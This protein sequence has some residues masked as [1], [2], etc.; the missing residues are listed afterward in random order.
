MKK[1][2]LAPYAQ[3]S[4]PKYPSRRQFFKSAAALIAA[5]ALLPSTLL[6][7]E[8]RKLGGVKRR[9]DYEDYRLPHEGYAI[10][11]LKDGEAEF[12]VSFSVGGF[13]DQVHVESE[14]A[15]KAILDS[16]LFAQHTCESLRAVDLYEFERA[17]EVII[18]P[19]AQTLSLT[20]GEDEGDNTAPLNSVS[21][22]LGECKPKP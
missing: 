4:S 18:Q 3:S 9:P 20:L 2:P 21:F 13:G 14:Q 22:I 17:L 10:A 16:D 5:G 11:K 15:L 12:A 7:D 19:F 1:K 8:P 6:A